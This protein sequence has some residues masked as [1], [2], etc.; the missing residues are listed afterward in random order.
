[1]RSL[2]AW[3]RAEDGSMTLLTLMMFVMLM[4][5]G[6]LVAD[7]GRLYGLHSQ[8]Q[9]YV[10]HV[11]LAGAAE[12]DGAGDAID[13]ATQA[14]QGPLPGPLVT[15]T[16][17]FAIGSADLAIQVPEFF[18]CLPADNAVGYEAALAGCATA[19]AR[20]ARFVRVRALPRTE[21]FMLLPLA[22][23][24]GLDVPDSA[25]VNS[26]AIAGF[27]RE[28][29]NTP[30][31]MMCNP[32]EMQDGVPGGPYAPTIGQQILLKAGGSGSWAPGDFGLL[33]TAGDGGEDVCTGGLT[34]T[35][36]IRCVLALISPNSQCV[37]GRVNIRPGQA[38]SVHDGINVRFD[39][40]DSPLNS[41][42]G[43][44]EFRPARNVMKGTVPQSA[45]QC[46]QNKQDPAPN[47]VA[48]P[49]DSCFASGTCPGGRFG[50]GVS[51]AQLNAYWTQ[52]HPT[53]SFPAGATTRFDVYRAE[54]DQGAVPRATVETGG[55]TCAGN[56]YEPSPYHRTGDRRV[57]TVAVVNC[58]EHG[59]HGNIDGVPVI[60]FGQ[61][62]MTEPVSP[63]PDHDFYVEMMGVAEPGDLSGILHDFPV[64]YR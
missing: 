20:E 60:A 51:S 24:V 15:D 2:A 33:D 12:L 43:D 21:S 30:P 53:R 46:S 39:I 63:G 28:V 52:N 34:G 45:G 56:N 42:R 14:V 49:R 8:M 48:L 18:R 47:T 25:N 16:Q 31:M 40:W 27:T 13:R 23:I 38:T 19:D 55:P 58:I 54:L 50:N 41:K 7:F 3:L 57:I 5:F 44:T 11:A 36:R 62:F 1:M 6:A 10:D 32:Y 29:C 64:L 59:V 61:M 35:N 22:Q 26:E 37:G 17:S 4:G 9:A